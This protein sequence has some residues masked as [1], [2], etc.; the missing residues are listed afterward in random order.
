ME[1]L[2]VNQVVIRKAA[3]ADIPYIQEFTRNTFEWGDYVS[4]EVAGW[5]EADG[6]VWV[7]DLGGRPVGVTHVRYL[8]GSHV[9]FEGI[10]VHPEYRK[11]GIGKLLTET[12][13]VGARNRQAKIAYAAIEAD[14]LASQSLAKSVGFKLKDSL[15]ELHL[16]FHPSDSSERADVAACHCKTQECSNGNAEMQAQSILVRRAYPHDAGHIYQLGAKHVRF[17]G[18]DFIWRPLT[19]ESLNTTHEDETVYVAVRQQ[20]SKKTDNAM[21]PETMLAAAFAANPWVDEPKESDKAVKVTFHT[22]AIYGEDRGVA[23]IARFFKQEAY[24]RGQELRKEGYQDYSIEIFMHLGKHQE[25]AIDILISEGFSLQVGASGRTSE[26]GIWE[27][28]L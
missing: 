26:L 22:G 2:H 18:S 13:I 20:Q 28:T 1:A 25:S 27:L 16:R 7:A 5:I 14:N 9:W 11:H 12:S 10:R 6:D 24:R 21:L 3:A 17:V 8:S 19:V 23:A 4:E 15:V